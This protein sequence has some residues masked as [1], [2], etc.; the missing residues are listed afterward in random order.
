MTS[1]TGHAQAL[2]AAIREPGEGAAEAN[3]RAWSARCRPEATR[4][5]AGAAMILTDGEAGAA[6]WAAAE[7]CP[8]DRTLLA[9]TEDI[10][11]HVADLGRQCRKQSAAC[12]DAREDAARARASAMAAVR[13]AQ[14]RMA[15]AASPQLR[16][17]AEADCDQAMD[18][19]RAAALVLADCEAAAEILAGS[20]DRLSA[21]RQALRRV[22]ADL[23]CIY[24]EPYEFVRAGGLLP[25]GGDFLT[26]TPE[27]IKG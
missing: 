17:D 6:L 2:A 3:A 14:A 5:L 8:D 16:A 15:A 10:A 12:A 20:G 1:W 22:P 27:L 21:A 13:S 9:W 11:G 7:P 26:G 4:G 19:A 23:H 25:H 24:E 18:H